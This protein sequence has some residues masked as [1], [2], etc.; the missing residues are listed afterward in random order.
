M[1]DDTRF[2]DVTAV[3]GD[4]V[5]GDDLDDIADGSSGFPSF[6][7]RPSGLEPCGICGR[8]FL[9][10]SLARHAPICQRNASKGNRK[11]FDMARQR[12]SELEISQINVDSA[13]QT[14]RGKENSPVSANQE[15]PKWRI[16]HDE[17]REN[18]RNAREITKAVKEGKPVPPPTKPAG[19][20]PGYMQCEYCERHFSK[21]AAER[22]IEFCK[23][24]KNRLIQ[25]QVD[26]NALTRLMARTKYKAPKLKAPG[27]PARVSSSGPTGLK[28]PT[29]T[30]GILSNQQQCQSAGSSPV[31]IR[32]TREDKDSSVRR[33]HHTLSPLTASRR[34]ELTPRYFDDDS[35]ED[36][37]T[38]DKSWR[39]SRG[40][41]KGRHTDSGGSTR[42][43]KASSD[44]G[45]EETQ[46]SERS[47]GGGE[48]E[49]ASGGAG[50][51]RMNRMSYPTT[52]AK[53]PLR[54][55]RSSSRL[56][57]S[58][59]RGSSIKPP[60][61]VSPAGSASS[62]NSGS[63]GFCLKSNPPSIPPPIQPPADSDIPGTSGPESPPIINRSQSFPDKQLLRRYHPSLQQPP[64]AADPSAALTNGADT[65]A[66]G[67][68]RSW[69]ANN[70]LPPLARGQ[71]N[72]GTI[73]N[74]RAQPRAHLSTKSTTENVNCNGI[75][76]GRASAKSGSGGGSA[77]TPRRSRIAKQTKETR[78]AQRAG[79]D[80][81]SRM[82]ASVPPGADLDFGGSTDVG[83]N[84][85][86]ANASM[87]ASA[88]FPQR[89]GQ[90]KLPPLPPSSSDGDLGYLSN[91]S[92]GGVGTCQGQGLNSGEAGGEAILAKFCHSCGTRFPISWA[93][94]CCM[95]G[96]K[97]LWMNPADK[98]PPI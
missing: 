97:R 83:S 34:S 98:L 32:K 75:G 36:E 71:A 87:T 9:P 26:N 55:K 21:T 64:D 7:V 70:A 45:L 31:T 54:R 86:P 53:G 17:L 44:K 41:D 82:T 18:I 52:A 40:V 79:G 27:T 28:P 89:E 12:L 37:L 50:A 67:E 59:T 46:T 63:G 80:F 33:R 20:R 39:G 96:E 8:T 72:G 23:E 66:A 65:A 35:D 2:A 49:A 24:Q 43:K 88:Y 60:R 19:P 51:N 92:D 25:P 5:D 93:R 13:S 11:Q 15:K 22:H 16:Q 77:N 56:A 3:N 76:T 47:K 69:S 10:E 29:A 94:F 48:S 95:C 6:E 58:T 81:D 14:K 42:M 84:I 78:F 61:D 68:R 90:L 85:I 30:P 1:V 4:H 74:S 91:N 73:N 38:S 62:A 57:A